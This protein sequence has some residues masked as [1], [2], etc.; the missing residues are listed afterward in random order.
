M[1][2]Y[3]LKR[4]LI[5]IVVI[6][7]VTVFVF[8]LIHILPGDPARL[9][10]GFE[11]SEAEVQEMRVKMNLDKPLMVQYYLWLDNVFH[12]DLGESLIY[13]RPNL[14]IFKERLPRTVSIGVP[15]LLISVPIALFFGII[16]AVK[17]GK[18]MDNL[19]TF[20]ITLGMGTP[21]FWVSIIAIY[22]FA[23]WLKILPI[24]GYVSPSENFSQY[25][26]KATLPVLCMATHM[27]AGVA[28]NTRTYMLETL[29]QDYVRTHRAFGISE[30]KITCKYALKNA[31]IPVVTILGFQVRVIIGG[32]LLIEQVFNIPGL[33]TLLVHAVN[34]RDYILIQNCVLMIATFTVFVSLVVDILYGYVDP[35]IRLS[36][37]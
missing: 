12:G 7:L 37:R 5:S 23:M 21:V 15:A 35:R 22:I 3:I 10:L 17:R 8:A 27:V 9:Y 18:W 30:R 20:F 28:R 19:L 24:Q 11:A 25:L 34:S 31:L 13:R 1:S 14:D 36:R 16:C 32:S 2:L 29:N 26:Y 33:G 6:F 4:I